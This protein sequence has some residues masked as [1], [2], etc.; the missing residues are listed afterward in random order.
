MAT[1]D[2][3]VRPHQAAWYKKSDP[4]FND[5]I[6]AVRRVLWTPEGFAMS[7]QG[8]ESVKIPAALLQRFVQ[9]LCLAA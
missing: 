5:A 6:A 1:V 8:H 7:R 2:T 9:P 4:T 3:A